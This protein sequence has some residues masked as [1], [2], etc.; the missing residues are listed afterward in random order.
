MAGNLLQRL[1]D[2]VEDQPS[3]L[4]RFAQAK[5]PKA[6]GSSI[7]V[8]AGDSYA[9]ALLGF[10]ASKGRCIA[11]DPYSLASVP[12]IAEGLHVFFI[13]ASGMTSSN[14]LAAARVK[15]W[16]GETTALTA[17]SDSRLAKNV[18]SVVNLPTNY[19]PK[20]PGLLSFSLSALAVLKIVGWD[21]DCDFAGMLER[22]KEERTALSLGKGT[23]YFLGNS[24]AYPA[25]L[26]AAAKTYEFFGAKAHAEQLEEFSHLE[27][28]SLRKS[29]V[30]NTFSSFDRSGMARRLAHALAKEGYGS[31]V[32]SEQGASDVERFFHSVFVVQLWALRRSRELGL[33]RP[34]F[35]ASGVRLT[36]SDSMIY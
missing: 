7:F 9:A 17:R 15:R 35:L 19:V 6:P 36:L 32:V 8:G 29:D 22:A 27:L 12:E 18:D 4:Q 5:I 16:A 30:V 1:A 33:E 21:R 14:L 24:L 20:T 3:I 10:Y 34:R 13:S 25:A 31:R 2:E 26:Y 28:F 23:T 11:L